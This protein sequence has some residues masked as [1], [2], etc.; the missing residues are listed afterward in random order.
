MLTPDEQTG[1]RACLGRIRRR[2]EGSEEL[3]RRHSM[4]RRA[5]IQSDPGKVHTLR[6]CVAHGQSRLREGRRRRGTGMQPSQRQR[7]LSRIRL[8]GG[9]VGVRRRR[10]TRRPS[11]GARRCAERVARR[12]GRP[13]FFATGP[14]GYEE[15][16]VHTV[17]GRDGRRRWRRGCRRRERSVRGTGRCL[18]EAQIILGQLSNRAKHIVV[19]EAGGIDVRRRRDERY[20]AG[21]HRRYE[22]RALIRPCGG[23]QERLSRAHRPRHGRIESAHVVLDKTQVHGPEDRAE[24]TLVVVLIEPQRREMRVA[25]RQHVIEC[26]AQ[27][28]ARL[29]RVDARRQQPAAPERRKQTDARLAQHDIARQCIASHDARIEARPRPA[30]RAR[31]DMQGSMRRVGTKRRVVRR[32]RGA[33]IVAPVEMQEATRD[34][35]LGRTTQSVRHR[36][37]HGVQKVQVGFSRRRGGIRFVDAGHDVRARRAQHERRQVAL[38]HWRR[39]CILP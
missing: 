14:V 8:V 35:Q 10:R 37:A 27:L 11:A 29:A 16:A 15:F 31:H 30:L 28:A 19:V 22:L 13:S 24:R 33:R 6:M 23:C 2:H 39:V 17:L 12:H 26:L 18:E 4:L 9:A 5:S 38:H 25:R 21:R 34:A 3:G 1:R 7:P 32:G 20:D 36:M